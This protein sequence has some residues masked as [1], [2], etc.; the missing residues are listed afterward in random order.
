MLRSVEKY[1][2]PIIL[3]VFLLGF[4]SNYS[5]GSMEIEGERLAQCF[6]LVN[7]FDEKGVHKS[8]SRDIDMNAWAV[9][10][11][12]IGAIL[13]RKTNKN[14]EHNVVGSRF[15]SG[16]A[17]FMLRRPCYGSVEYIISIMENY[18]TRISSSGQG[19]AYFSSVS[20]ELVTKYDAMCGLG[21][22]P[23]ECPEADEYFPD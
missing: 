6:V 22:R 9:M 12:D 2:A 8:D 15:E 20:G 23:E 19:K 1:A 13:N 4:F 21:V 17:V 3:S 7:M 5:R 10:I 14:T 18:K 16:Y 11:Q